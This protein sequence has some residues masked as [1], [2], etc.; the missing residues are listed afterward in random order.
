MQYFHSL[1]NCGK[2]K[3]YEDKYVVPLARYNNLEINFE[4]TSGRHL[5]KVVSS[6]IVIF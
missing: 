6:I 1:S 5:S 3:M 2:V 4:L